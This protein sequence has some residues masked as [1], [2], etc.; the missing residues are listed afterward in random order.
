MSL[1]E[2]RQ[3]V[4]PSGVISRY[5]TLKRALV[6]EESDEKGPLTYTFVELVD[7]L[8]RF[9]VCLRC[10]DFPGIYYP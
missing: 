3:S 7:C 1:C 2:L 8:A 5:T 6:V 10:F 9:N 4:G